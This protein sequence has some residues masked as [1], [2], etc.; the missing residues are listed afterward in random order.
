MYSNCFSPWGFG[1]PTEVFRA[2]AL[3]QGFIFTLVTLLFVCLGTWYTKGVVTC[4]T[5]HKARQKHD[6]YASNGREQLKDGH[7]KTDEMMQRIFMY[8]PLFPA[9]KV[10]HSWSHVGKFSKSGIIRIISDQTMLTILSLTLYCTRKLTYIS[11]P[12]FQLKWI[13]KWWI[14]HAATIWFLESV[15]CFHNIDLLHFIHG[16][17]SHDFFNSELEHPEWQN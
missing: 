12:L 2:W 15:K 1:Q 7:K 10:G 11:L 16:Y 4:T 3:T 14:S 17:H 6:R 9:K 5:F 13:C 8:F